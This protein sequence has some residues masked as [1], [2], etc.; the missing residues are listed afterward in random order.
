MPILSRKRP[1]NWTSVLE[2]I[3]K[4][5]PAVPQLSAAAF[6][7]QAG[8]GDGDVS[9]LLLIDAREP[10]EFAVSHIAGAR[11]LRTVSDVKAAQI[12]ADARIV[13]YCS[14]GYRSSALAERLMAAGFVK[15]ANLEGSIF[16]WLNEGRPVVGPDGEATTRVHPF[17]DRWGTLLDASKVTAVEK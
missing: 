16:A 2:A 10:E 15:V 12:P 5:Y 7:E 4:D 14:V 9:D 3:R 6:A 1:L 13:L 17:S 11:N 8:K